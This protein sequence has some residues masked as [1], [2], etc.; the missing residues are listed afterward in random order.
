MLLVHGY[1]KCMG[2]Q[3]HGEMEANENKWLNISFTEIR[4]NLVY[5][6]K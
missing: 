2:K 1:G 6:Y 5:L 4:N 3:E